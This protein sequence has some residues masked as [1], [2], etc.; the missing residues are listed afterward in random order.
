MLSDGYA[1][2]IIVEVKLVRN[3]ARCAILNDIVCSHVAIAGVDNFVS[4]ILC[5]GMLALEAVV[6]EIPQTDEA[7]NA[8]PV[9]V[10]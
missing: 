2:I 4:R 7:D 5:K 6:L 3:V 1:G 10:L 9:A 8:A